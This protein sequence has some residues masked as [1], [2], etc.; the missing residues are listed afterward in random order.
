MWTLI[1]TSHTQAIIVVLSVMIERLVL[2]N[3]PLW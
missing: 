3:F 2:V 1:S